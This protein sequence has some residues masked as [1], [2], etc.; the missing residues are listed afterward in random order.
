MQLAG[1]LGVK[2]EQLARWLEGAESAPLWAFVQILD[3]I[4]DGAYSAQPS[5][6]VAAARKDSRAKRARR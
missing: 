1:F 3:L 4:A 6:S 5:S 2:E